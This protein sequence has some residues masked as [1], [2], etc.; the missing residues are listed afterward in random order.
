M[1]AH[2]VITTRFEALHHWPTIPKEHPSHYLQHPH[3]HEFYIKM[4]CEVGHDDREIEFIDYRSKI[5]EFLASYFT[6]DPQ[7]GLF[8]IGARSCEMLA[9]S[10]LREFTEATAVEVLEDGDMGAIVYE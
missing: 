2:V 4:W 10:I 8:D 1:K 6:V 3:R 9:K 7:S 5:N